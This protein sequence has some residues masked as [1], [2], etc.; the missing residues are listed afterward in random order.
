MHEA[1]MGQAVLTLVCVGL[2]A[3]LIF[4]GWLLRCIIKNRK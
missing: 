3:D 4:V 2:L 1:F